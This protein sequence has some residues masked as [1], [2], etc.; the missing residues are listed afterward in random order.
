MAIIH[1][2]RFYTRRTQTDAK[3][4]CSCGWFTFGA[5]WECQ[6]A[7]AVHDDWEPFEVKHEEVAD[8]PAP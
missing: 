6:D 2:V 5:L 8:A 4:V 1:E 3:A 7:A